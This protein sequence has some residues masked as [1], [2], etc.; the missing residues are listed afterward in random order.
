MQRSSGHTPRIGALA[1]LIAISVSAPASAQTLTVRVLDTGTG[2]PVPAAMVTALSSVDS[3]P[4]GGFTNEAGSYVFRNLKRE[5]VS[6]VA[7]HIGFSPA[8]I[9]VNRAVDT[10]P[11]VTLKL[12][13][14]GNVLPTVMTREMSECRDLSAAGTEISQVWENVRTA[15]EATRFAED[16]GL[17][18]TEVERYEQDLSASFHPSSLPT[19]KRR[20]VRTGQPFA[21]AS[22]ADLAKTGYVVNTGDSLTYFAP[23]ARTLLSSEFM[24]SHCFSIG[25]AESRDP[26]QIGLAFRPRRGISTPNVSG[27]LWVGRETG[28]LNRLLFEYVN[29]ESAISIKGVGGEL[30]FQQLPTGAWIITHWYIRT[31]RLGRF[32]R[33]MRPSFVRETVDTLLGFRDV[34]GNAR[35]LAA[36]AVVASVDTSRAPDDNSGALPTTVSSFPECSPEQRKEATTLQGSIRDATGI[37]VRNSKLLIEWLAVDLRSG[38][39]RSV[40]TGA[41]GQIIDVEPADNGLYSLCGLPTS[42]EFRVRLSVDGQ[43]IE[44][45]VVPPSSIPKTIALDFVVSPRLP[46][47]SASSS[48]IGLIRDDGAKPTALAGAEIRVSNLTTRSDS[49]GRFVLNGVPSGMQDVSVKRVGFLQL[50]TSL[51]FSSAKPVARIFVLSPIKTRLDTIEVRADRVLPFNEGFEERRL[52]GFG[53]YL[54]RDQFEKQRDRKTS[55]IL[56]SLPAIKIVSMGGNDAAIAAMRGGRG[57]TSVSKGGDAIDRLRGAEVSACYMQVF[58]DGVRVF[59]PR[60]NEPLFNINSFTPS[61]I[62][63]VELYRGPAET[64][65]QYQTAQA[66]CGTLLVWT[67]RG[68]PEK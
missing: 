60:P 9:S 53:S 23:D 26:A 55:D 34:G 54:T 29:V 59:A 21:A 44:D 20:E 45:R 12:T 63:G 27:T 35:P 28:A 5:T 1:A 50:T 48:L 30:D 64:P 58:V 19:V 67:R 49:T 41:R 47:V 25:K 8:R 56:K 2:A 66:E 11:I 33:V 6:I 57:L 52:R 61:V 4:A 39:G 24:S 68:G 37:P 16:R 7:R 14:L 32:E 13:R 38:S 3:L 43:K 36:D 40:A 17:V 22:P 31:P 51:D 42:A 46:Q 10:S 65:A 15:L 62:E 18:Q